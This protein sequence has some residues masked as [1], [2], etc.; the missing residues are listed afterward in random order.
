MKESTHP[1]SQTKEFP[2]KRDG[3][4]MIYVSFH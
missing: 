4:L 2:Q 1:E 3:K